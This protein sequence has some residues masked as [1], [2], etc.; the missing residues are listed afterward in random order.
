M[1]PLKI[2]NFNHM[3]RNLIIAFIILLVSTLGYFWYSAEDSPFSKDLSV[4]KAVPVSS[5]FFIELNGVQKFGDENPIWQE[6]EQAGMGKQWFKLLRKSDSLMTA[7]ENIPKNLRNTPVIISFG[8]A[9]RNELF[10]VV[11]GKAGTQNRRNAFTSLLHALHSPQKCSYRQRQYGKHII[12]EIISDNPENALFYSFS[13]ELF[14]IS[15]KSILLEQ[16]LRQLSSPGIL[17]NPFFTEVTRQA[18][19]QHIALY[20]NHAWLSGFMEQIFSR[21]VT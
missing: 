3:K 11:I 13:G 9:G 20:I 10:P 19:D 12:H 2:Y 5:P 16:V 18:G 7:T 6:M 15:P 4:F 8:F 14:L 21:N 17:K 1:M